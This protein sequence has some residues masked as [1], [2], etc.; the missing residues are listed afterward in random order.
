MESKIASAQPSLASFSDY[1][2]TAQAAFSSNIL[3]IFDQL[4]QVYFSFQYLD[5]IQVLIYFTYLK[6]RFG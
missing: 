1:E 2:Q 3:P 6:R 5:F 4:S